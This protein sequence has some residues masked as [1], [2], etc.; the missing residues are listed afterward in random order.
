MKGYVSMDL[1]AIRDENL[2]PAPDSSKGDRERR[3]QAGCA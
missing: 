2:L 1:L 3:K